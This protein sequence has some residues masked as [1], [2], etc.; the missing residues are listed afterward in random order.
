VPDF[1]SIPTPPTQSVGGVSCLTQ[2]IRKAAEAA[3][4]L[5]V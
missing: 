3:E 1:S 4:G 5:V 2:T